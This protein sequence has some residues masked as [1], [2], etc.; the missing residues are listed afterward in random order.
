MRICV[1]DYAEALTI[2]S[3]GLYDRVIAR[4]DAIASWPDD[5]I[6]QKEGLQLS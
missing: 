3:S 2:H 1:V 5:V 6:G 4:F